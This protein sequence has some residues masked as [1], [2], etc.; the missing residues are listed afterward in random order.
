MRPLQHCPARLVTAN[1]K[2]GA[3]AVDRT[4]SARLGLTAAGTSTASRSEAADGGDA[5][6]EDGGQ[7]GCRCRR[8]AGDLHRRRLPGPSRPVL[9]ALIGPCLANDPAHRPA[10]AAIAQAFALP[11]GTDRVWRHGPV[12]ADIQRRE[13]HLYELTTLPGTSGPGDLSVAIC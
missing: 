11:R 12:A 6:P 1:T 2:F 9:Q 8:S 4:H 5:D 7:L 10:P 3:V 13:R